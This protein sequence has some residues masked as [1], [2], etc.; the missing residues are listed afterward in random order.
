MVIIP[1]TSIRKKDGMK[2][3]SSGAV[4]DCAAVLI[5][6][7]SNSRLILLTINL[8]GGELSVGGFNGLYE[9][10]LCGR[11]IRIGGL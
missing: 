4:V 10:S 9:R 5:A 2:T 3:P 8:T 1:A 6:G 11:Q 7:R